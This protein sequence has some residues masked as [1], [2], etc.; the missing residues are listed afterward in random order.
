[1]TIFGC[2]YLG[3]KH[4]QKAMLSTH[5]SG[6]CGGIFLRTFGDARPTLEAMM[7]SGK[8][9]EIVVHLAEFD[10]THKYP[11]SKTLGKVVADAKHCETL[12]KKYSHTRLLLS[13]YCESNHKASEMKPVF[14]KLKEAAPSCLMVNSIWKGQVVPGIITE[15]HLENSKPKSKPPGEYIISFDGFGGDGSGD[16]TDTNVNDIISRYPDARQIRLWNFRYNGKFGHKDTT[17]IGK[18]KHWPSKEYMRGH[19]QTLKDREGSLTWTKGLYKS[20]GDDHGEKPPTK[21]NKA[22]AILPGVNKNQVDVFD[23][24]GK[25]IASMRRFKPDHTGNPKG[26]RY[27][28]DKYA[29]QIADLA[30]KNTGSRLIRVHNMPLTD[31]DLRSRLFR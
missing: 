12:Q 8:F 29:Y 18:R 15:I 3:A 25:K 4:Y 16:F 9:S 11:I 31:G 22:L 23:K 20:F 5:I 2:D 21:D 19:N 24:N 30:E 7:K 6:W 27:Y 10:S 17:P 13:P 28:S 14:E 1:M 26:P